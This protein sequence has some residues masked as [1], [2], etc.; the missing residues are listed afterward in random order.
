M[1]VTVNIYPVVSSYQQ[2]VDIKVYKCRR[3]HKNVVIKS[4]QEHETSF[5]PDT[6]EVIYRCWIIILFNYVLYVKEFS[7]ACKTQYNSAKT[8]QKSEI[9]K[10]NS[11]RTFY[12]LKTPTL[13]NTF[14]TTLYMKID[15]KYK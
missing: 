9:V 14:H 15:N 2:I 1:T 7:I 8:T 6:D 10:Q 12:Q 4:K 3:L 5:H 11:T 13:Q